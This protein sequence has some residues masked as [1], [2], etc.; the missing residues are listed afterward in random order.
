[1]VAKTAD[2]GSRKRKLF[3][4]NGNTLNNDVDELTNKEAAHKLAADLTEVMSV[5]VYSYYTKEVVLS[6]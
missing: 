1:M 6:C 2:K 5:F 3:K 4:K